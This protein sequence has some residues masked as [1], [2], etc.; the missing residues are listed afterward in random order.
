M[1]RN[2]Y[3]CSHVINDKTIH[4]MILDEVWFK[5]SSA[6]QKVHETIQCHRAR[7]RLHLPR[8]HSKWARGTAK[9]PGTFPVQTWSRKNP[10]PTAV[11]ASFPTFWNMKPVHLQKATGPAV[12]EAHTWTSDNIYVLPWDDPANFL[13]HRTYSQ[14]PP[15]GGNGRDSERLRLRY[16]LYLLNSVVLRKYLS[17]L[18]G[19]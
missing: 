6:F 17:I 18:I 7:A 10:P 12:R 14:S 8:L 5:K 9:H 1:I 4:L 19:G 11:A 2:T 3:S 15:E 16:W 13:L